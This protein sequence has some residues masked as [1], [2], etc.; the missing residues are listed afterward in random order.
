MS[1]EKLSMDELKR[2]AKALY[3][4]KHDSLKEIH[5]DDFG[6]FAFDAGNLV[7]FNRTTGAKVYKLTREAV[8]KVD[9]KGV[10]DLSKAADV[11]KVESELAPEP[12]KA[13]KK[14]EDKP[15]GDDKPGKA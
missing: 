14:A 13:K 1:L 5:V 7:E 2:R 10:R 4:D 9:T 3:F 12:P 6:R 15:A 8:D 11:K